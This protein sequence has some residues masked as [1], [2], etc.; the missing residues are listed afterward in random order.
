MATHK[1]LSR[2]LLEYLRG[3]DVI[4]ISE[5]RRHLI[6]IDMWVGFKVFFHPASAY[7][8]AGE[9]L[10]LAIKRSPHYHILPYSTQGTSL[11]AKLQFHQGGPPLIVG[12]CYIPPSGSPL[13]SEVPLRKRLSQIKDIF[14]RALGEGHVFLGGDFNARVGVQVPM[15][16]GVDDRINTHGKALNKAIKEMGAYLCTGRI[17]GDAPAA[18]TFQASGRQIFT[19]LDHIIV[20][21][22][23]IPYLEETVIDG[24]RSESDH[25]PITSKLTF[26]VHSR[27]Q[28]ASDGTPLHQFTWRPSLRA[29][30]VHALQADDANHAMNCS[31]AIQAGDLGGSL[32]ALYSFISHAAQ[33]AGMFPRCAIP[34]PHERIRSQPFFDAECRKLKREVWHLGRRVGWK[35]EVF[36]RLERRYH[37]VVRR[38]RRAY[39]FQRTCQTLNEVKSEPKKF[40]KS[41]QDAHE[42]LPHTMRSVHAWDSFVESL[43]GSP[44]TASVQTD[45]PFEAYPTQDAPLPHPEELTAPFSCDEI[46]FCLNSLAN[47]R[48]PGLLGFPVEFFK[49]AR[50]L[51]VPRAVHVLSPLITDIFNLAFASDTLPTVRNVCLV[52]PIFK[53]GDAFDTGNYRP[54]A[55]GDSLMRLYSCVLNAR[56]V[57]YLEK[58]HLR[59]DTQTGFRPGM[60]T[61]HQLFIVQHLL[62]TVGEEDPL[63]FA[64]L[65]FSKAYDKLMR[66]HLWLALERLGLPTPFLRAIRTVL[67]NTWYAI[68]VE[69]RHGPSFQ[70]HIGVPQGNPI[71]PTLF[72]VFSDGLPRYLK[73]R[74]PGVGFILPNGTCIQIL[75][76]ADD[77]ALVAKSLKDLQ[78]L[79]DAT[80]AWCEATCMY[81]NI[82]KT[83]ILPINFGL[84]TPTTVTCRGEVLPVV[85]EASYLGLHIDSKTGLQ[86]S[87]GKLQQRFWATWNDMKRKYSNLR[88]AK[89]IAILLDL[90]LT[91]L[92]PIISYGCEV[93]AFRTFKR[94][95]TSRSKFASTKLLSAHRNVLC[96]ILGVLRTTA[97][98]TILFELNL[99]PLWA[100]WLLR[101][102]RFWNS[103]A[104]MR[105]DAFHHRVLSDNLGLAIQEGKETFAGT[106][107]L[108]LRAIGYHID[109]NI[110]ITHVER[111]NI[112]H[113]KDLLAR[114]EDMLW[115]G[116]EM[117]PRTCETDRAM[118]CRYLR[119][120]ARPPHAPH[121]RCVY[122]TRVPSRALETFIRFRLG[123]HGLPVAA[124][125]FHG[126]PRSARLCTR[127]SM[128]I[129]GDEHHLIFT[130]PAVDDIRGQFPQ[131]FHNVP[132]SVQAFM[133]Q[134]DLVSVINFV[135]LALDAYSTLDV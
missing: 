46:E 87:I 52:T 43:A 47:G 50:P 73:H 19:R 69:G 48:S 105:P 28:S 68:R 37:A 26:I 88:C 18:Y 86:A 110:S 54:I 3:F 76:Y 60:S 95:T 129:V 49:Y 122:R 65:D 1:L 11:W 72:G 9:G 108:Q 80:Q 83:Q 99:Q 57:S 113:I 24:T 35:G 30:Y 17:K 4:M 74:C 130:C 56:L 85:Q 84:E 25:L 29:A 12:T 118:F 103:M 90:Y 112:Q 126:I 117:S 135:S 34:R 128:G 40:W 133:W 114:K 64:F 111:L 5:T 41:F 70:S 75:G 104:E 7:S 94:P 21:P 51:G 2:G 102:A 115:E 6:D 124:G 116:L 62:D 59:D 123:C 98:A 121:P 100:T 31:R 106:L 20:S 109:T 39:Q 61:V 127:C 32:S 78:L 45:P 120:F 14:H 10:F 63:V 58:H 42:Q 53:K 96:D 134:R 97:E 119:W 15:T 44:N 8:K 79:L 131:L 67:D 91:C 13:L 93:W 22:S 27:P 16:R 89:S 101:M 81:L 66:P 33:K 71:S 23:M 107:L 82:P 36:K 132:R 125:R 38:K 77:F 92:P 55:V